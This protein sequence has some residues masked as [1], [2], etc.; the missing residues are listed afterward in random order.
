MRRTGFL[1]IM[2]FMLLGACVEEN[3]KTFRY[4]DGS[5][6]LY[7]LETADGFKLSYEPVRPE[8]SSSGTY[9][10]GQAVTKLLT[11]EQGQRILAL[12]REAVQ[13][14]DEHIDQRVMMSGMILLEGQGEPLRV[15]LSPQSPQKIQLESYLKQLIF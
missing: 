8:T 4:L 7:L 6:N 15:I 13:K 2:A 1:W 10:G 11:D 9:S 3:V 14:T 12:A 5:G